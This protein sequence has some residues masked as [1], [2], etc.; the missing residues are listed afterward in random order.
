MQPFPVVVQSWKRLAAF[1]GWSKPD[2]TG[3]IWFDANVQIGG[4]VEAGLTLHG[5]CYFDRPDCQVTLELRVAKTPGRRSVP[6]QRLD[7]RALRGHTNPRVGT[8]EWRGR[9][10]SETHFHEFSLNWDAERERL[11][12][13][14]RLV[15]ARELDPPIPQS[16]DE[17]LAWVS[18]EFKFENMGIITPPP[19]EGLLI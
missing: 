15:I 6:L 19:W 13:P 7:W 9:T 1:N 12:R 3:Y 10:V 16:F 5:G 14:R 8:S 17:I 18:S 4:V 2:E 11:I